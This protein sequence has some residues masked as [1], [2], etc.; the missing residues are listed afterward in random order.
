LK[1]AKLVP[2]WFPLGFYRISYTIRAHSYRFLLKPFLALFILKGTKLVPKEFG[3]WPLLFQSG[4]AW[5][6]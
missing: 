3:T 5:K 4:P 2:N 1:G 6:K